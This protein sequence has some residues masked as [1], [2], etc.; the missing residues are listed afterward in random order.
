MGKKIDL[1][2]KR[3]NLTHKNKNTRPINNNYE[4]NNNNPN[5][6]NT[7]DKQQDSNN[8]NSTATN[9]SRSLLGINAMNKLKNINNSVSTKDKI[10]LLTKNPAI[11][12]MKIKL[13]LIGIGVFLFVF[14][15]LFLIAMF[16]NE[17]AQIATGGYY[18]MKCPEVTVIFTDKENNYEVTG[19]K[20]YPL[21]EYVAGVIAGEVAFLGSLEV[22]K[23]FAIAARS[24]L[25]ANE[26]DCTIES[27]DRKQV[28]R[29]LTETA[30]DKLALQAAEETKGKVLLSD[31]KLFSSQYDAFAC[32]AKDDNYYTISQANQKL[33]IDWVESKI[34][35]SSTPD[36][37]VCDGKEN[38]RNHHGNGISQYGSLYLATELDYTYDQILNFYLSEYNV[39]ISSGGI[40]SIAGLE[41]KDTTNSKPLKENLGQYLLNNGSS[42]EEMNQFIYNNVEE[43]GKGTRAGVVTAAVSFINYLYDNFNVRIPYY[44]GGE[45]QYYGVNPNFGTEVEGY[46]SDTTCYYYLG[47]DCSGFVSWAIKNGGY[48]IGR[49]TTYSFHDAFSQNSC[50]IKDETCVGQPGDLINT[51][52]SHVQLIVAVDGESQKYIIAE[53]TGSYGVIMR[54]YDMHKSMFLKDTRIL[55]MDDYY[56]NS[57][58]VD[59]NY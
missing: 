54:E 6:E 18:A 20:T 32:I 48:N 30:T 42:I 47:F 31:N 23:T 59:P 36:W 8:A 12:T 49:Y 22:D 7:D 2:R 19:T 21:E 45:Y 17:T 58:N 38:L 24:Y 35:P 1:N 37:F 51:R 29:E 25:F 50:S 3:N 14:I 39:T 56:N 52:D 33:P 34:N 53:S 9:T 27:S 13:I 26:T 28:F 40:T 57:N 41:V 10:K 16:S 55:L 43:A 15:V 11:K 5:E 46:C 4:D 44:W